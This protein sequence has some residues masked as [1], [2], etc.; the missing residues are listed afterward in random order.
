MEYILTL[1][2]T[3]IDSACVLIFFEAFASRRYTGIKHYSLAVLYACLDCLILF[4]VSEAFDSNTALKIFLVTLLGSIFGKILYVNLSI[5]YSALLFVIEYLLTYFL[6]F[7]NGMISV[8]VSGMSVGE[9]RESRISFIVSS[10]I[11]YYLELTLMFL[12]RNLLRNKTNIKD[13]LKTN[14]PL[15]LLYFV[16]P[17]AS[18]CILLLLLRITNGKKINELFIVGC[19]LA[20]LLAN[21]SIIFLLNQLEKHKKNRELLLTLDQQLQLQEKNMEMVRNL[22][23]A[24]RKQVHDFHAHINMINGLLNTQQ[25]NQLTDYM[26]S[27]TNSQDKYLSFVQC[28]NSVLDILFNTKALVAKSKEI[29]IHFNITELS[30]LPLDPVD[31]TVLLSNLIDNAIE[32]CGKCAEN[33][34]IMISALKKHSFKFIIRNTS[35][36][37]QIVDNNIY[38]TKSNPYMHGF[39]LSNIKMIINKYHGEYA[40]TYNNGVFSFILEIDLF[41]HS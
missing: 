13:Q 10:I 36:P 27:L 40:M 28:G 20:I 9:F 18:F 30:D 34:S 29:D 23:T 11:Y 37:V 33:R 3:L 22:Y 7:A 24:Q 5:L 17:F 16:F 26:Q 15:V 35:L 31:L 41:P 19:C 4:L 2:Y 14:S 21:A 8:V 32:A 25:Y 39:G 6:S 1:V 12:F 38:T